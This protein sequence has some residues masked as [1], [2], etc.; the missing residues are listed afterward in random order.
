[1]EIQK[2]A[3]AIEDIRRLN[4]EQ[5]FR[6][7]MFEVYRA[8]AKRI[9]LRIET[10][11]PAKS[12]QDACRYI[13]HD[14]STGRIRLN[15]VDRVQLVL[16]VRYF[17]TG[18]AFRTQRVSK[19]R[20]TPQHEP[21]KKYHSNFMHWLSECGKSRYTIESY[22]NVT[23]QFLNHLP[24]VGC[25]KIADLHPKHINS[26]FKQLTV[27]WA[28]TSIRVA[29]SAIRS[30]LTF[31]DADPTFMHALPIHCPKH[32]PII[33]VLTDEEDLL[34]RGHLQDDTVSYKT[35]A[36]VALCYYL[37]IRA[38]DVINLQL[39]D[40]DWNKDVISVIQSKTGETVVLPLIPVVGNYLAHYIMEE[41]DKSQF[42]N[43]F[44]REIAPICPLAEH[45]AVYCRISRAFLKL[46]IRKREMQG[47]HLLRHSLAMR[48]IS[49]GTSMGT[50]S[51]LLGH[52][53]I[54]TTNIYLSTDYEGLRRCCIE[55][56]FR[57]GRLPR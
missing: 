7:T 10:T 8:S 42:Q 25:R 13:L 46:H 38:V 37:G 49:C 55:P 23:A 24:D 32:F 31:L 12:P 9:E 22:R 27:N 33:P 34:L 29:S 30:F 1:M 11:Y 3:G 39:R 43:V 40:I 15:P 48:Q 21:F 53:H 45:S 6:S 41:R 18:R 50:I 26:F 20:N 35:K 44:L 14:A 47:S 4:E 5:N 57:S 56:I 28:V 17:E 19:N 54:E 52:S 16:I 36:M 2:L 51:T